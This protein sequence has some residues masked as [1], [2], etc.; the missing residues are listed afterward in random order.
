MAHSPFEDQAALREALNRYLL[1]RGRR[2]DPGELAA[3]RLALVDLLR[4]A[5]W[6]PPPALRATLAADVRT[7][8]GQDRRTA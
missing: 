5:G 1:A 2:R 6:E 4:S 3:A 8:H 7:L